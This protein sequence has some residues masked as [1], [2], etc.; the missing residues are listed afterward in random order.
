MFMMIMKIL[1]KFWYLKTI[2]EQEPNNEEALYKICFWTD[3]TGRNEEEGIR[4]IKK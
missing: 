1:R 2:L 3:F 4:T